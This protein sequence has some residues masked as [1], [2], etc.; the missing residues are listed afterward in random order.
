M[1]DLGHF[2]MSEDPARFVS[3]LLPVLARIRAG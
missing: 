3:Y 2:P 1:K